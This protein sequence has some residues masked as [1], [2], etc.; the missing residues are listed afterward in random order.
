MGMELDVYTA[1]NFDETTYEI[2]LKENLSEYGRFGVL[3]NLLPYLEFKRC[4]DREELEETRKNYSFEDPFFP[5]DK[6]EIAYPNGSRY[7]LADLEIL[8]NLK[9]Q[10]LDVLDD[11]NNLKKYFPKSEQ[12]EIER[13]E[14]V[15]EYISEWIEY[16]EN[17]EQIVLLI[18]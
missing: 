16:M 18:R 14:D 6:Y 4:Y 15:L 2:D 8:K 1:E 11:N 5:F 12:E 10:I 3:F 7:F 9:K 17:G 13:F